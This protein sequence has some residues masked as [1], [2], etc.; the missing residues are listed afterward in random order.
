MSRSPHTQARRSRNAAERRP[1]HVQMRGARFGRE[2]REPLRA[3][4]AFQGVR[5]L[6]TSR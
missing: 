6:T 3:K 2:P 5:T 1:V 4:R